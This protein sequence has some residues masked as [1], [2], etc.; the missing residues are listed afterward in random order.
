MP[1]AAAA[2][3][4]A[5]GRLSGPAVQLLISSCWTTWKE[6]SLLI[7]TLA[8][9]LPLPKSAAAG[10]GDTGGDTAGSNG[11]QQQVMECQQLEQLGSLQLSMLLSMKHNGA[12]EKGQ[13]GFIALVER[14]LESPE[15]CLNQLP[16]VW[17]GRCLSRV[18]QPA[19]CRDDIVRRSAGQ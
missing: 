16:R 8:H 12:V 14:L 9:R 2:A 13:A 11:K 7:G 6:T 5:G 15:P 4:A 1:A 10:G 18:L 19:Q 3:A 17:L